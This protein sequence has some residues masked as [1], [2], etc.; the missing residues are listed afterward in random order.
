MT[1]NY[2]R[3][4]VI[5]SAGS[6]KT[7]LARRLAAAMN[8]PCHELDQVGYENGAKRPLDVRLAD[9][10]RIASQPAWVSEGGF[11]WW[12]EDL[13]QGA[14][15]IVWL[16]LPWTLCYRRVVMRHVR[17][18]LAGN[19]AYP[20]FLKMLRFAKGVRPYS[21]DTVPAVPSDPNDDAANNRA[22][23]SQVLNAYADKTIHCR[24]PADVAA[25]LS[26][27]EEQNGNGG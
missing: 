15:V 5:G 17:A 13:L 27:V 19:N 22:A 2:T 9:V 12:V 16:D 11:V 1:E 23:V 10:R 8:A 6:G 18:D 3:I 25:F 24:R 20:G 21:L 7:T 4:H 26:Q 14:D